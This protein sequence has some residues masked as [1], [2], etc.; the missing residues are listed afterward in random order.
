MVKAECQR[1]LDTQL[2]NPESSVNSNKLMVNYEIITIAVNV[3]KNYYLL[4]ASCTLEIVPYTL[5]C[6][7]LRKYTILMSTL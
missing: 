3:N 6:N 4:N 2:S 7:R 1:S 5:T